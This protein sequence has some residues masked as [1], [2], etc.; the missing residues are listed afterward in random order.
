MNHYNC[1]YMYVNKINGKR[2]VGKAKDFNIRHKRHLI[3]SKNK[4]AKDYN[5]A[6]H[7]AIRKYGIENFELKILKE[8]IPLCC[9]GFYEEYY[10]EKYNTYRNT[11]WGYNIAKC[12]SGGDM[13]YGKTEE[14]INEWKQKISKSNKGKQH[15]KE[16]KQKISKAKKGNHHSEET[17]QKMSIA[18]K[19]KQKSEETKQ[20]MSKARKGKYCGENN[21]MYGKHHSEKTKQLMSGKNNP[22]SIKIKQEDKKGNLIKIWNSSCEAERETGIEHRNII[23]CCKW[24][25]C[26]ESLEEWH[27]IRK[28]SPNKSAGGFIWKYYT[29]DEE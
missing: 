9:L 10:A 19:G 3:S 27:K 23:A 12:G 11:G 14:E 8:N 4:K 6:I 2:Y 21:P 29:E 7:R 24:Y 13:R 20:K 25:A 26:G 17:K 28:S 1:I 16:A 5:Y 15:S 18:K 22:R